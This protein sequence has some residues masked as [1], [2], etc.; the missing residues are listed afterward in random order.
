MANAYPPTALETP[1]C[2]PHFW[3]I[4]YLGVGTCRKCGAVKDFRKLQSQ[5]ENSPILLEKR[6]EGGRKSRGRPKTY[7]ENGK[8]GQK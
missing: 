1:E 6:R 8:G 7:Q 2:P 5:H 3:D 4:D